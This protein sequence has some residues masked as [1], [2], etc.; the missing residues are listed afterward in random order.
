MIEKLPMEKHVGA[1]EVRNKLGRFL[2]RVRQ[3]EE[4]LVVEKLG[5]PVAA[6]ISME[7]YKRYRRLLA[8]ALLKD[9]GQRM[10]DE[11]KRQ[12]LTEEQLLEMMEEDRAAV[13]ERAYGQKD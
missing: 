5:I 11:I 2:N 3:G 8:E 6:V 10:G 13:Y 9:L 12:G 4:H 1:T 7:D